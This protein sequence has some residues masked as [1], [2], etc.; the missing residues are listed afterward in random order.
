[1]AYHLTKAP[2][3]AAL[4]HLP[5]DFMQRYLVLPIEFSENPQR[6][7]VVMTDPNDF[8][9]LQDLQMATGCIV[10]GIKAEAELIAEWV[11]TFVDKSQILVSNHKKKRI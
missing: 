11:D 5:V 4:R 2:D 3:V 10:R 7:T 1:M 6:L 9:L 8:D